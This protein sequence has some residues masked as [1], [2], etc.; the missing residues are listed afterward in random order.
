[1]PGDLDTQPAEDELPSR[2][3]A[4]AP[5]SPFVPFRQPIFRAVWF[6]TL[7]SNFGGLIQARRAPPG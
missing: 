2:E 4:P 3:L 7:A 5:A 1:M 6:A